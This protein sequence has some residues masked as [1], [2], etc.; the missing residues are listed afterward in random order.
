MSR[1]GARNRSGPSADPKSARSQ[2]RDLFQ[3]QLPA[4]GRKGDPPAVWPL[5]D[6]RVYIEEMENGKPVKK[7]D[8]DE[9]ALRKDAELEL[10][11]QVWT[12]P[13]AVAWQREPWR[14]NLVAMWVR[15]FLTASGP[16]AKAADKSALHRFGDQIGLTPAGLKENGWEIVRD[17]IQ[18]K[19]AEKSEAASVSDGKLSAR[20]R[21]LKAVAD[22]Q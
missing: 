1:G 18:E 6:P 12:Y 20:E 22:A 14:W 7:Y 19:R 10:W 15:T 5:A 4:E 16:E 8:A 11:E 2:K 17:E 13:Q 9:S 21:R 3:H